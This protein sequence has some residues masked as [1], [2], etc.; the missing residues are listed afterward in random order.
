MGKRVVLTGMLLLGVMGVML[1]I[2]GGCNSMSDQDKERVR[3][4]EDVGTRYFADKY[5]I[6]V[7]FTYY[8]VTPK[9]LAHTVGHTGHIQGKEDQEVFILVNYDNL[10]V[11][12]ATVP[13]GVQAIK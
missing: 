1:L 7:E 5:G 11:E 13:E 2:L 8:K 12:A 4:T 10:A 9:G 3:V 6:K